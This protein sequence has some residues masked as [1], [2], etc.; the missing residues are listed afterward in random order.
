MVTSRACDTTGGVHPNAARVQQLLADAG[1][2]ATVVELVV[3]AHTSAEAA[4]ALGVDVAQIAKSLV[5]GA[6]DAAVLVVAS[7]ADRVDTVR[8]A[9]VTGTTITRADPAT[10]RA[11]TGYDVGGV[12][13]V[14]L[15]SGLAVLVDEALAT[16]D[17]VWAA[18]GTP[19]AVFPASFAELLRIAGGQPADV[20]VR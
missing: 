8:L 12:S 14:G 13:P 5:F 17:V 3:S 4:A 19:T 6:G 9:E 2:T 16:H 15:P 18:A 11:A 10:V 1:S 7:G 20:R